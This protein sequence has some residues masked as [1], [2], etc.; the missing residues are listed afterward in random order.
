MV[1]ELGILSLGAW[2]NLSLSQGWL[3]VLEKVHF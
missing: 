1:R 2:Y 3:E